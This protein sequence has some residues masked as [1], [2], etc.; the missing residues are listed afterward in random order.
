MRDS[1]RRFA[2]Y[3]RDVKNGKIAVSCR[4]YTPKKMSQIAI[5]V[6]ENPVPQECPMSM[7][8]IRQKDAEG[9]REDG[10]EFSVQDGPKQ[11][12]WW[13]YLSV[14]KTPQRKSQVMMD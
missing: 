5:P 9:F 1:M 2:K 6:A 3:Q 4:I 7:R 8:E 13:A 11:L 14:E 10:K 12:K